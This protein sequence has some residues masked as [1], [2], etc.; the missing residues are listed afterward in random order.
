M[1]VSSTPKDVSTGT[2]GIG[3]STPTVW[4]PDTA[5]TSAFLVA[6]NASTTEFNVLD[7]RFTTS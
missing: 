2:I 6:N 4:G 5:S 3:T 1:A 7:N